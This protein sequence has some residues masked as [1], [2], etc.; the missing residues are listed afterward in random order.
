MTK[1]FLFEAAE[2]YPD[3]CNKARRALSENE[4]IYY[5]AGCTADNV[6]DFLYKFDW[7]A[8]A[9]TSIDPKIVF[10]S[11]EEE[12]SV[13]YD[14]YSEVTKRGIFMMGRQ[15]VYGAVTEHNHENGKK[16]Y[17]VCYR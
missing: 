4:M 13:K 17:F 10:S 1:M 16:E 14:G 12:Y 11:I 6:F 15:R 3:L 8:T 9:R 7:R 2:L 5:L